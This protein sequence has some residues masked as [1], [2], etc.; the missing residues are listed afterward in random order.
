MQKVQSF[1]S[2]N[3]ITQTT[4]LETVLQNV[5]VNLNE[6]TEAL[7]VSQKGTNI[8]LKHNIE[9]VFTNACNVDI[10]S[11]WGGGNMDLQPV[12]DDVGAV[13]YVCSY[14]TKGEKAMGE[15]LKRVSKECKNDDICTQM[16]KIKKEFLGKRVF[17]T[18]ESAMQILS[19]WLMKKSRKVT[20]VNTEMKEQR[21][22]LPK[23][24]EQLL[25]LSDDDENVFATSVIDRYSAR[26][27]ELKQMCLAKFPVNYEPS[28]SSGNETVE[29]DIDAEHNEYD[30]NNQDDYMEKIKLK[31]GLGT[32]RKRKREAIL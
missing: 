23:S 6:Y 14:M 7:K 27:Q 21:V 18:P 5:N 8:I 13:M 3:D 24:Q 29:P 2:N 20:C 30:D 32:M 1:I 16:K 17:G 25:Q 31:N 15:T 10:L 19:M 4:S 28:S 22:S 26:P 9:D 12:V 11:L